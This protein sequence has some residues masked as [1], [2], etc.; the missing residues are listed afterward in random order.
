MQHCVVNCTLR[1]D[2]SD[3]K[4]LSKIYKE[5]LKVNNKKT[6]ELILKRARNLDTSSK[7]IYR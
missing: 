4:D 6:N 1:R 2:I 5:L 3:K 7:K